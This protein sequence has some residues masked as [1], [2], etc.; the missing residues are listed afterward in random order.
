MPQSNHLLC[1]AGDHVFGLGKHHSRD[2]EAPPHLEMQVHTV[3]GAKTGVSVIKGSSYG[4]AFTFAGSDI[5]LRGI[6]EL[7]KI[8]GAKRETR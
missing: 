8:S 1:V 3:D 4:Y 6:T 7:I 2:K 5:Y